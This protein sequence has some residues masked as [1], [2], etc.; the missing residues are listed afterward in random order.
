[1]ITVTGTV[2]S[3]LASDEALAYLAAFEHTP[4]WD[5]GTPVVRKL[6]E[7][8]VAVGHRY[9]AEAEFRG[10]RQTL[11]YEV[12]EL[13]ATRIKLRGENKTVISV[14]TIE[15]LPAGSGSEVRYKAEFQL[16]GW[17]KI[18]E[19]LMKPAFQSLADPAMDGMKKALDAR[20]Q[21]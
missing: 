5:P 14:D 1:M 13:T 7:G 8:P 6:S 11:V 2:R 15:V 21:H 9:H 17:L 20:A 10:K 16:K 18:A 12:V 3:D 4:E 19:P